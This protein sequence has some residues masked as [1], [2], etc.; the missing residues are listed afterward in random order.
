MLYVCTPEAAEAGYEFKQM[1]KEVQRDIDDVS[2]TQESSENQQT[3]EHNA[4][5]DASYKT[6]DFRDPGYDENGCHYA[7]MLERAVGS[8]ITEGYDRVIDYSFNCFYMQDY[9]RKRLKMR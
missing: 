1:R 9:R 6:I 3:K 2:L 7:E 5:S 8:A 4:A